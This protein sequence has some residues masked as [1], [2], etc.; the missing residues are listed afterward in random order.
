MDKDTNRLLER[1]VAELEPSRGLDDVRVLVRRRRLRA[2]WVAGITPGAAAVAG[3]GGAIAVLRAP[4]DRSVS[5]SV[6]PSPIAPLAANG[7]IAFVRVRPS[8]V[9]EGSLG[10]S[11]LYTVEPNGSRV[12]SIAEDV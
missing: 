4:A 9:V 5:S 11:D 12:S 7:R 2:R 8:T 3:V 10:V 1:V 6:S